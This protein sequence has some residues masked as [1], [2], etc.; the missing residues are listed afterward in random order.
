MPSEDL[1]HVLWLGGS[2][3]AGKSTAAR[4]LAATYGLRLYSCDEQFEAHRRRASPARH[5]HFCRLM[6]LPG[7][8]L[9][10]QPVTVQVQDL[11]RF[12]EDEFP[13]IVE[14]LREIPGP[15]LAEGVGLLPPLVAEVLTGPHQACWLIASPS[16]R[17]HHYPQRGA[18]IAEMLS[19]C[20]DPASA[21]ANWMARDDEIARRLESQ[22]TA[23]ALS[24]LAVNG[25][26]SE[27]EVLSSLARQLRL[28][29]LR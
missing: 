15:V 26:S 5:P 3:C 4:A 2:A 6:D 7:E 24:C 17:R 21:Y 20:P 18:W 12:Y 22:V 29:S 28:P 25:S 9:W 27:A 10:T 8:A 16:F 23:L 1:A 19:R 14:D 11:L 13:L